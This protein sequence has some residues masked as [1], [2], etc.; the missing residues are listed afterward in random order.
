MS[1]Q[2]PDNELQEIETIEVLESYVPESR[3]HSMIDNPTEIIIF[4]G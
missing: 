4:E 2:S 3:L 1:Q